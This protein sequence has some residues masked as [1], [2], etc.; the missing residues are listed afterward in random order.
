[1]AISE[2]PGKKV[3]KLGKVILLLNVIVFSIAGIAFGALIT[4][5]KNE[6]AIIGC[7]ILGLAVGYIIGWLLSIILVA[8]GELVENSTLI[9][10]TLSSGGRLPSAAGPSARPQIKCPSCGE[11]VDGDSVFCTKCGSVLKEK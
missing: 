5:G 10:E 7:T 11:S 1:M 4:H 9:R 8:F 2:H 6:S 3:I